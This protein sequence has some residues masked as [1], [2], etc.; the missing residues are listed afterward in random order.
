MTLQEESHVLSLLISLVAPCGY[1]NL[2]VIPAKLVFHLT[3]DWTRFVLTSLQHIYKAEK[4]EKG[5]NFTVEGC[6]FF[7]KRRKHPIIQPWFTIF[8]FV[9]DEIQ[10]PFY[11]SAN[12]GKNT[13]LLE[14]QVAFCSFDLHTQMPC[15][16]YPTLRDQKVG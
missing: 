14:T 8:L 11:M 7:S 9:M 1:Q 3:W 16:V 13:H 4:L 10:L 15:S 6:R 5:C 2:I 12:F